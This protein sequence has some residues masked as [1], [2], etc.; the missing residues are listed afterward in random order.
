MLEQACA[1]L[2]ETTVTL[3]DDEIR[4]Q[5]AGRFDR[6]K[7]RDNPRWSYANFVQAIDQGAEVGAPDNRNRATLLGRVNLGIRRDHGLAPGKRVWLRNLGGF[8]DLNGEIA[9]RHGDGG[10]LNILTDDNGSAPRIHDDSR[11]RVGLDQEI[12]D[13]RDEPGRPDPGRACQ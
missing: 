3:L 7:D 10:N 1:G 9:L 12:A 8:A 6:L 2:P 4:V 13:F 5:R 11:G